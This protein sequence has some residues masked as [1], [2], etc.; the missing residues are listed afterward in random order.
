MRILVPA[1]VLGLSL[2]SVAGL[3]APVA[4]ELPDDPTAFADVPGGPG[5][6][7]INNNCRAC[8]SASM[9]LTQPRLTRSEWT[10]EVLKMRNVYKA[11]VDPADDA[12]II[13]WLVAMSE[14]RGPAPAG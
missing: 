10:A 1:A 5:A 2:L 7:A 9:V 3:S 8:H 12:A 14:G 13:D 6:E 11:P 4:I